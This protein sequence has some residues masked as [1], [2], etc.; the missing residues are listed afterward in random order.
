[1]I[2]TI[3]FAGLLA[4]TS[5]KIADWWCT[6]YCGHTVSL[7]EAGSY[8]YMP[9]LPLQ[10]VNELRDDAESAMQ[11]ALAACPDVEGE[12]KV[13]LTRLSPSVPGYPD[14]F[15]VAD[16]ESACMEGP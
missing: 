6:A 2:A 15:E 4:A 11:S 5:P 8:I 14:G 13:L 1:M 3:T 9:D 16:V 7:D 12:R 10:L